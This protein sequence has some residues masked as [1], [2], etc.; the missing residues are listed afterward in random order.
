MLV[1]LGLGGWGRGRG[2]E[3]RAEGWSGWMGGYLDWW[4]K[5]I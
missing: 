1:G 2:A 5:G 4:G 3:R